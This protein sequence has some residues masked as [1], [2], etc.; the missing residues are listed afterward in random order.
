MRNI[1]G[2]TLIL[3]A[4][5][6][7]ITVALLALAIWSGGKNSGPAITAITPT[8]T[9]T[10]TATIS[11]STPV[12]DLSLPSSSS[13]T[14]DIIAD[15]KSAQISGAQVEMTYDPTVITNVKLLPPATS[16]SLFGP[17]GNY[18]TLFSDTKTPGKASF[19]VAI[20]PTGNAVSGAGSI[21][22]ISF[23]V[24]KGV[25]PQVQIIFGTGTIVTAK[26]IQTSV[27]NSTTPLTI[28]LQ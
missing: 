7:T 6:I 18:L 20:Q 12:L 26:G 16:T 4:V 1:P 23:S 3:I 19:A 11:F 28:K 13:A 24:I 25:K 2:K 22:Q 15:T 8:P 14:V 27:L 10:K 21:G 9:I 5:L 17:V